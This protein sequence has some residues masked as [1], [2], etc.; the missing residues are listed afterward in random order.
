MRKLILLFG[1]LGLAVA[2]AKSYSLTLFETATVAGKQLPP[3]EYK[4]EVVNDKAVL[5][6]GKIDAEAPVK[7]EDGQT[8]YPTT[9]VRLARDGDTARIQEIHLGGTKTRLVFSD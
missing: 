6:N 8:K 3:G 7:V 4:V 2:S 5:R 1:F 9:T